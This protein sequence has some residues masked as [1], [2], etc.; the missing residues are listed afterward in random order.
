MDLC[1]RDSNKTILMLTIIFY[2]FFFYQMCI[3]TL[4]RQADVDIHSGS[5]SFGK[6]YQYL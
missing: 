1:S 6:F 2:F 5:S 3:I 4:S